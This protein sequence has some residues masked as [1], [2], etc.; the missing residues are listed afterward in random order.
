MTILI[1]YIF[2]SYLVCGDFITFKIK[3]SIQ[4]YKKY[5]PIKMLKNGMFGKGIGIEEEFLIPIRIEIKNSFRDEF[6]FDILN[7]DNR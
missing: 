3:Q 1:V 6:L 5:E 7:E 2:L 4:F